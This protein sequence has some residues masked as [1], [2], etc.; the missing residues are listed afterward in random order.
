MFRHQGHIGAHLVLG[1]VD[2]SGV[3]LFTVAA[4]GSTDKLPYV[5][6][7]SGSLAAMAVFE[8]GW[9]A[10]MSVSSACI[11][12]YRRPGYLIY[13]ASARGCY[14]VG[15]KG[16]QR[17]YLQ[18][19]WVRF[20]RRR[21]CHHRGWYRNHAQLQHAKRTRSEGAVLSFPSGDHGVAEEFAARQGLSS[22]RRNRSG[23]GTHHCDSCGSSRCR[24]HGHIV[25]ICM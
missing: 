12:N 10:N 2:P 25:I 19:P 18:R 21:V 14:R 24:R 17:R 4:H 9:R 1:G 23:S 5:T 7:G 3:H 6:M 20:Q 11:Q 16:D 8:S 13:S 15:P 22:C